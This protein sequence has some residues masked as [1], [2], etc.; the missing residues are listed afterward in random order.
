MINYSA[1]GKMC[2]NSQPLVSVVVPV[3][4]ASQYIH[5]TINCIIH[6]TYTNIEIL[7]IDDG[8]TDNSLEICIGYS[9][10]DNR[11]ITHHKANGGVSS[12]RN[13]GIKH[14]TG[15]FCLFID[16]DDLVKKNYIKDMVKVALETDS[17]LVTCKY[18]NGETYSKKDF[19]NHKTSSFYDVH[20]VNMDNYR[21]TNQ[22]AHTIVWAA[23]YR[24]SLISDEFFSDDL[25][26]GED[27]LFF[28]NILKKAKGLIFLNEMYYYYT[29]RTESLVHHQYTHQQSSEILAWKRVRDLFSDQSE[30]FV[31]E[32][33]VAITFV[34]IKNYERMLNAGYEGKKEKA[35]IIKNVRLNIKYVLKS[36]EINIAKKCRVIVFSISPFLEYWLKKNL[37][38][39]YSI[40]NYQLY[41]QNTE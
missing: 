8:S 24:T 38:S 39:V 41:E 22:Y 26:V 29:Y 36:K 18:K 15:D 35:D 3:Y 28:A 37:K 14:A 30:E 34:Y 11:I 23:L 9:K 7:L 12:A 40:I 6:Q 21:Y 25:Y 10:L 19:Y 13:Y 33:N 27:T 32:C 5:E 17:P 31:N 1:A 20:H 16:S 4:N 2:I